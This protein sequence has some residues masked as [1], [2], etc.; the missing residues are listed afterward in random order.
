MSRADGYWVEL[1]EGVLARRYAELDLTVGLVVGGERALVVDTRGDRA[2]GAELAAAVREVTALPLAVV[3][4]HA[5]FDHCFGTSP[6]V[7]A[8]LPAAPVYGH[9]GCAA[10]LADG[11]E[12]QRTEWINHYRGLGDHETAAALA[13]SPVVTPCTLVG[14]ETTLD[15]GD[16]TVV[17]GHPGRAHTDHDLT[18]LVPDA[19]VLFAGDLVEQGAPPDFT[20]AYPLDWPAAIGRLRAT[21][22]ATVVPGH[23][24]PVAPEFVATQHEELITV[25]GLCRAVLGGV[26]SAT[27]A[28]LDSPYPEA[29]TRT[30]LA[31]A[32]TAEPRGPYGGAPRA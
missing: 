3:Y 27:R 11:A 1:A 28:L 8:P 30:A 14:A 25:A 29:T 19:E 12:A 16:R 21:G 10:A 2:Q 20:D 9:P 5:H 7:E 22:A 15:L 18:V 23:G 26:S 32:R 24:D 6:F 31:R 17:L 13:A 4:T